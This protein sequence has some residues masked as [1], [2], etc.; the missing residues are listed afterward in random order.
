[1]KH[2]TC[3]NWINVGWIYFSE[4]FCETN[5]S[6]LDVWMV[7]REFA[8]NLKKL[9]DTYQ[10]IRRH[11]KLKTSIWVNVEILKTKF[12]QKWNAKNFLHLQKTIVKNLKKYRFSKT[13]L[14]K[15]IIKSQWKHE[16]MLDWKMG[17]S[18]EC[19]VRFFF[20]SN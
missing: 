20:F 9:K 7:G 4:I 1:M 13:I 6:S 16:L 17:T 12:Y 2:K 8:I 5:Y 18:R 3:L 19:I 15:L 10:I 14:F 11:S